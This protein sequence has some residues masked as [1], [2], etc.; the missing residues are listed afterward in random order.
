LSSPEDPNSTHVLIALR[1]TLI[2]MFAD[3]LPLPQ[4]T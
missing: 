4:V 2:H 3:A 1:F